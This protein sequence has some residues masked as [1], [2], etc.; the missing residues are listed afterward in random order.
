LISCVAAVGLA[1]I[2]CKRGATAPG[3]GASH[4]GQTI[5]P[6]RL[7]EQVRNRATL[8]LRLELGPKAKPQDVEIGGDWTATPTDI[9]DGLVQVACGIANARVHLTAGPVGADKSAERDADGMTRG[10]REIAASLAS[11]QLFESYRP[12]GAAVGLW[13][14]RGTNPSI[15]NLLITIASA[16][17]LV[18]A[19]QAGPAW[20]VEERDANGRYLAAYRET[21]P[22]SVFKQKARYLETNPIKATG[23]PALASVANGAGAAAA[24]ATRIDR[25]DFELRADAGGRLLGLRGLEVLSIDFG[26]V[27]LSIRTS[28]ELTL[29]DGV[30]AEAPERVGAFARQ[31]AALVS[32]PMEQLGLDPKAEIARMDRAVLDGAS[33]D[34]L[35]KALAALPADAAPA[36]NKD[37][38]TLVRRFEALFR[39]DAGAAAR[40]PGLVVAASP[41]NDGAPAKLVLDA[42]SL[43]ATPAAATALGAVG[44]DAGVAMPLRQYAVQYISHQPGL[45]EEA[46]ASVAALLD[47]RDP[48]LR[49]MARLTYGACAAILRPTAPARGRQ[50]GDDLIA[51]LGSAAAG[52]PDQLD[53]LMAI[54]NAGDAQALPVLRPLLGDAQPLRVHAAA[55]E[56]LRAIDAPD[57]DPLLTAQLGSKQP[58]SVRLAA[59]RAIRA[60]QVGPFAAALADVARKD[61]DPQIRNAAVALLGDR[62][63]ALPTL[64][65]ILEEVRKTDGAPKNRE[66]ANR[67]LAQADARGRGAN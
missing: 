4:P 60:R 21:A 39:L 12:D 19:P 43:A 45:S 15:G 14:P 3:S 23:G 32:Q 58:P 20:V 1:G 30:T 34:E 59:I 10:E 44:K 26:A 35:T 9:A 25:S 67:Y 11:T 50:I 27:G 57:V 5:G 65:P 63:A 22:G 64:R 51:R 55:V 8:K 37:A 24:P 31:R 66:L 54:A 42:L 29:D 48:Q 13:F 17:Q 33:F 40:A 38:A 47:D 36:T 16:Q 41:T 52:S 62:M 53:F 18:R 56:A 2:A 49:Q 61:P 6:F 7:G 28:V 46:V